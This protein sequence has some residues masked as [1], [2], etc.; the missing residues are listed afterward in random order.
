MA[1]PA[2]TAVISATAGPTTPA[3]SHVAVV[4]GAGMSPKAQWM[5]PVAARLPGS[6]GA[7]ASGTKVAVMP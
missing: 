5:Q 7:A 6:L 4:P 2:A 1:S 3:V